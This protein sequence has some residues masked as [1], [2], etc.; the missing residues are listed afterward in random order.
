MPR[1][2]SLTGRYRRPG[3]LSIFS[4]VLLLVAGILIVLE[5]LPANAY[6]ILPGEAI[7]V[8][9]MISVQGQPP[10]KTSGNLYMTDVSYYKANHLLEQLYGQLNPDA[11]IEQVQTFSGGLSQSQYEQYNSDLMVDSIQQAEAAALSA[12][13]GYK[14]HYLLLGPEV[15][16]VLPHTPAAGLL[17]PGDIIK[18][19][20]GEAVHV[21]RSVAPLVRQI[22]PGGVVHLTVDRRGHRLH[23][24]VRTIASTNGRPNLHGKTALIGIDMQDRVKLKLP[25]K[26][27]VRVGNIGGPSAGLMFTLGIIQRLEHRDLTHGCKVAGTGTIDIAGKVGEIG[28]A[29]QKVIAARNAGARYFLVPDVSGNLNPARAHRGNVTVVPV[30]TLHQALTFL[31]HLKPCH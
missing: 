6:V 21:T 14:P 18:S 27:T 5:I 2:S 17:Q 31:N 30:K 20:N 15:V 16:F 28:G 12:A 10:G 25:I 9:P 4:I 1:F 3:I 8:E 26:I 22:R 23:L 24:N 13:L 19:V 11:D 7:P 29:K